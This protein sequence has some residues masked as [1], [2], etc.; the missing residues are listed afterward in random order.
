MMEISMD[1]LIA[2]AGVLIEA[3][4]YIRNFA[5][6][7][8]VIKY[9]GQAMVNDELKNSVAQDIILLKFIGINPIVVH[10]GGKEITALMEKLGKKAR[11]IGG[12]RVTDK[13]TM[14]TVEMVLVGK[15]NKEIV[16]LLNRHGG[17]AVGLSGK[18]SN[19][20]VARKRPP[21]QIVLDGEER[22]VDLGCVGDVVTVSPQVIN[23][24][25]Q[26]GY[27]PVISSVGVSPEGE[28][29][30]INADHVAGE[31]AAA[32]QA[33]KLIILTDVEGIFSD[34]EDPATLISSISR[35]KAREMIISGEISTGMIPKVEACVRALNN[36]VSR[37]HI[38][39]GRLRHSMLLEIFTD[40]GI[41]TMV[42]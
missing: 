10:G 31:L 41:G 22:T 37:T 20:L 13:E 32:L 4:P 19:L 3:L 39:D 21:V 6:K 40:K 14:E 9:G 1:A 27:I 12:L 8:F 33:E 34:P 2:K 17:R 18:D 26:N 15:V 25:S 28:G 7:T 38:I 23:T 42:I 30:N 35:Q 11:F 29:L 5:G 36:N 16:N 24:L